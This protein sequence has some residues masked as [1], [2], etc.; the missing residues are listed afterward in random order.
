MNK[1]PGYKK[2]SNGI[3]V[4]DVNYKKPEVSTVQESPSSDINL[5]H[6]IGRGLV[7]LERLMKS[8]SQKVTS[9]TYDRDTVLNLKDVMAMLYTIKDRESE[10]L[11]DLSD[12]QL[13]KLSK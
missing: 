11:E 7:T 1:I 4:K 13:E 12:E 5:D 9:E 2:D 6:L 8:V 3:I 10:L